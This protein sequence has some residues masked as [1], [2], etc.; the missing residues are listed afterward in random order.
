MFQRKIPGSLVVPPKVLTGKTSAEAVRVWIVDGA[1][2]VTLAPE[3]FEHAG[4]W[5][6]LL[7]DIARHVSN[8][9]HGTRG[10]SP[11]QILAEIRETL[12][13]EWESPTDD[14]PG[15]FAKS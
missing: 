14:H 7:V 10:I 9:I 3:L 13:S 5:G 2:Q 11:D 6:I 1:L 12:D 8:A 4:M 15:E